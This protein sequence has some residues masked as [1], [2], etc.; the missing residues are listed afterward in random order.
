[1]DCEQVIYRV[2]RYLDGELTVWRR[3]TIRRHLRRCP[4]C[5]RGFDFE[6]VVRRVV[7]SSCR[8]EVPPDL[9]RR[10]SES[11]EQPPHAP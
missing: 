8:D 2:Y 11:L 3:W 9:V 4:P 7:A 6:L 5:S 10:V 1:M